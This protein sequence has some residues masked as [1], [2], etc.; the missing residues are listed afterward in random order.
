MIVQIESKLKIFPPID[1][2]PLFQCKMLQ[3]LEDSPEIIS[4]FLTTQEFFQRVIT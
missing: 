2:C 4:Y 1:I 3:V